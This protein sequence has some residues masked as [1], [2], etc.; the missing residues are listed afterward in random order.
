M[1]RKDYELIAKAIKDVGLFYHVMG[2]RDVVTERVL[3][4]VARELARE[5]G[6]DNVRFD[7]ARFLESCEVDTYTTENV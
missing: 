2:C 7:K 6:A 3:S 5:L 1:T 4:S